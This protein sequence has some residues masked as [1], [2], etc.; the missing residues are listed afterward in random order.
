MTTFFNWNGIQ[1]TLK[2]HAVLYPPD[3]TQ[4]LSWSNCLITRNWKLS[5]GNTLFIV[6]NHKAKF[7]ASRVN[8]NPGGSKGLQWNS[9]P[10][11]I[12]DIVPRFILCL[13]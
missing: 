2:S 3:I 4:A 12:V 13:I 10:L 11:S 7:I 6:N 5:W 8:H 1:V 9:C